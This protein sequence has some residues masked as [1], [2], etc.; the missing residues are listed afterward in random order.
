M[1]CEDSMYSTCLKL[2]L[3]TCDSP[4]AHLMHSVSG[5]LSGGCASAGAHFNPFGKTHGAPDDPKRHV[6]DLGNIKSD[7]SGEA[8]FVL[9]DKLISLNGVT[10]IVG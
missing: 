1:H 2:K 4:Y 5:D 3:N 8:S 7:A 6:G 10:S 9:T